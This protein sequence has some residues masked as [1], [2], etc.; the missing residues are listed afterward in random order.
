MKAASHEN[1]T[2]TDFIAIL[3]DSLNVVEH[4]DPTA[5]CADVIMQKKRDCTKLA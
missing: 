4:T 5:L 3:G 2:F 1:G